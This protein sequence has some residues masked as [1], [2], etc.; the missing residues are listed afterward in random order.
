MTHQAHSPQVPQ[1]HSPPGGHRGTGR[2]P[3]LRGCITVPSVHPEVPP[4]LRELPQASR[5][6]AYPLL[7]CCSCSAPFLYPE[8]N[9]ATYLRSHPLQRLGLPPWLVSYPDKQVM[10][11]NALIHRYNYVSICFILI[12][13]H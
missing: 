12:A 8:E 1:D 10:N 6:Q 4:L 2:G 3:W 7:P 11:R 9:L 5:D 13:F